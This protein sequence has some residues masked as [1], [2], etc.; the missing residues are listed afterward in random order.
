MTPG[1]KNG[2]HIVDYLSPFMM[3]AK[4]VY[5][6]SICYVGYIEILNRSDTMTLLMCFT[7]LTSLRSFDAFVG[8]FYLDFFDIEDQTSL[9]MI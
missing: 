9:T 8:E 7:G 5:E 1:K 3:V 2:A 6:I 4:F